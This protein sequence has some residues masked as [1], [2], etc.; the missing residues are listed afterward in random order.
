MKCTKTEDTEN[1]SLA[2]LGLKGMKGCD[3][4]VLTGLRLDD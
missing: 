1:W 2:V 4:D 3:G